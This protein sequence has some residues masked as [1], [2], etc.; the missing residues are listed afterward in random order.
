V[1]NKMAK[2]K[3][4]TMGL[5]IILIGVFI[6]LANF[7]LL[8][9]P[10]QGREAAPKFDGQKS[11]FEITLSDQAD[12]ALVGNLYWATIEV[13]NKDSTSGQMFVQCSILDRN[14]HTWL[15]QTQSFAF[16]DTDENCVADEPFTQTARVTLSGL[17]SQK[18]TFSMR[19]PDNTAGDNVLYCATFEQCWKEDVD[20]MESDSFTKEIQIKDAEEVVTD[21]GA[22]TEDVIGE[23][24][25]K[26]CAT[27]QDC[28]LVFWAPQECIDGYCVDKEDEPTKELDVDLSDS[29][30]KSWIKENSILSW[31]IGIVLVIAG[32]I[33]SFSEPKKPTS[34]TY[35]GGF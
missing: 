13:T 14:E 12:E 16:L 24:Q 7:N 19:V 18:I 2:K 33:Y 8:G 27:K 35:I 9:S 25:L 22:T 11:D 21:T 31:I 10:I 30:I 3:I 29:A 6:L 4:T 17:Q 32:M 28:S 15:P 34:S 5:V 20:V 26:P 1:I 23:P